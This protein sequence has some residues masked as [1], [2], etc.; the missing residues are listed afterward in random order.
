MTA[1][2]AYTLGYGTETE[3]HAAGE[4]V[5][6]TADS[7]YFADSDRVFLTLAA[8]TGRIILSSI[9]RARERTD[10][11]GSLEIVKTAD[12]LAV[13]NELLLE[14]YLYGVVPSEMPAS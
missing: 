1:D 2:C 3:T 11:R 10:Y 4:T 13:V 6:V 14:E 7:A 12:G 9:E 5:T 8:N